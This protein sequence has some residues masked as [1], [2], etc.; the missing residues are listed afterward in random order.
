MKDLKSNINN[1]KTYLSNIEKQAE[2][3]PNLKRMLHVAEVQDGISDR[4]PSGSSTVNIINDYI[5]QGLQLFTDSVGAVEPLA[6]TFNHDSYATTISGATGS[7]HYITN[8]KPTTQEEFEWKNTSINCYK[9]YI[10]DWNIRD[11]IKQYFNQIGAQKNEKEFQEL[12]D[13]KENFTSDILDHSALG[14]KIRNVLLHFKGIMKKA[15]QISRGEKPSKKELS[16]PKIGDAIIY[17]SKSNRLKQEFKRLGK[18]WT[19]LHS[20]LSGILKCYSIND[21]NELLT[22]TTEVVL[23][24]EAFILIIDSNKL[25]TPYNNG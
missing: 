24:I 3:L 25:K 17:N 8:F 5:N 21:K 12:L 7:F 15:A 9:D 16:W 14:N 10:D 18:Q 20:Q 6:N 23:L 13:Y 11:S 22:L 19:L 1:L 2:D 4:F